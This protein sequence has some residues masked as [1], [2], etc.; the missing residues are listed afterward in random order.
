MF[1]WNYTTP[2]PGINSKVDEG[3]WERAT[4]GT[5]K[6]KLPS[7]LSVNID[8]KCSVNSVTNMLFEVVVSFLSLFSFA[9]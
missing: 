7:E 9:L 4:K 6:P 8:C 5:A 1:H 2:G 3:C